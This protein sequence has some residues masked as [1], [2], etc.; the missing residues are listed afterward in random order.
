MCFSYLQGNIVH[1]N[2]QETGRGINF[3]RAH[4]FVLIV[5]VLLLL[6]RLFCVVIYFNNI[7]SS[8]EWGFLCFDTLF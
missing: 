2:S 6:L 5:L 8:K 7:K 3:T 1:W 4:R